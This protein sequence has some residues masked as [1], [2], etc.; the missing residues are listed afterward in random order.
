M[1]SRVYGVVILAAAVALAA[2]QKMSSDPVE[3]GEA[4]FNA[5]GC[6]KCHA[7]GNEG[8]TY[9]PNLGFIGFRKSKAWLDQWLQN[10]HQWRPQTV[11]PNFHL[12]DDIRRDLVEYLAAQQGQAFDKTGGRPWNAPEVVSGD[13]IKRGEL[14]F[15]KAG[16][17][18]CH[19]Q[20]GRGGYPNNNVVG[21]QIP[22]LTKVS[23]GYTKPELIKKIQ[24]G[25]PQPVSADP[26]KPAPMVYMPSWGKVLKDDEIEAVASYL[27]SLGGSAKG[28]SGDSLGF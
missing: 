21:G 15:N 28:G 16:C 22:A 27:I 13:K 12:Q 10:P 3:R 14:L 4:Y 9:G 8:G 20:N 17:V 25:V 6:V 5:L 24:N 11:M 23:E 19:S 18:A 26:G 1:N 2:C 7:M